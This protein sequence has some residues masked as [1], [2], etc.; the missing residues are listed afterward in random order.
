MVKVEALLA[1]PSPTESECSEDEIDELTDEPQGERPTD[2]GYAPSKDTAGK[3]APTRPDPAGPRLSADP[4]RTLGAICQNPRNDAKYATDRGTIAENV[5]KWSTRPRLL[6]R[7]PLVAVI[8]NATPFHQPRTSI[9]SSSMRTKIQMVMSSSSQALLARD[10][11]HWDSD[12][13]SLQELRLAQRRTTLRAAVLDLRIAELEYESHEK[14]RVAFEKS[15]IALGKKID[16]ESQEKNRVALEESGVALRKEI[17]AARQKVEQTQL[18]RTLPVELVLRILWLAIVER[19]RVGPDPKELVKLT[20]ICRYWNLL[21]RKTGSLWNEVEYTLSKANTPLYWPQ[22]MTPIL[23]RGANAGLHITIHCDLFDDMTCSGFSSFWD[24]LARY[25]R[26][27]TIGLA[28]W[29]DL[30]PLELYFPQ[31]EQLHVERTRGIFAEWGQTDSLSYLFGGNF[32]QLSNCDLVVCDWEGEDTRTEDVFTA[33]NLT[34]FSLAPYSRTGWFAPWLQHL[35]LPN[36][37]TL[38]LSK[39]ASFDASDM[40]AFLARSQPPLYKLTTYDWMEHSVLLQLASIRTLVIT[41]S[42]S[43]ELGME[44]LLDAGVL[45]S[46]SELDVSQSYPI[47]WNVIWEV[48]SRRRQT[49]KAVTIR[50]RAGRPI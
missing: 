35:K 40:K 21:V 19:G 49:L 23:L 43:Q 13:S 47:E 32:P 34:N 22:R 7:E 31:L 15:S 42:C 44:S 25:T 16:A 2:V 17:N 3:G 11:D 18:G 27:L 38:A 29:E 12:H 5:P 9:S 33:T 37:E 45:P 36:L 39:G 26:S 30:V 4:T 20:Q 1:T 48:V 6:N 8:G 50:A 14:K 28:V 10:L 46:L 24:N 41:Q